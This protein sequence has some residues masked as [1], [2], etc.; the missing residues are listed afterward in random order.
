MRRPA[1]DP[2]DKRLAAAAAAGER[3]RG[4]YA[5]GAV[6]ARVAR[7]IAERRGGALARLKADWCAIAGDAVAGTA[8]PE[9][10]D[11]AG[12]LKLRVATVAA[13]DLQHRTPLLI[14]RINLFFG[15]RVVERIMLV[16]GP[17]P[18]AAP[19]RPA[20]QQ[21][22]PDA[23]AA[24]ALDARLAGV[25]DPALREALRGLGLLLRDGAGR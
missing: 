25:C 3:R 17:L 12:R 6:A 16:Q 19:R 23:A 2:R 18:L 14:E 5:V 21:D 7:P 13:L 11:R 8:W 20:A 9:A 15:G 1:I 4:F 24:A 22:S 10:L